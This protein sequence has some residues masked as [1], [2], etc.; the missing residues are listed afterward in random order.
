MNKLN[1]STRLFALIGL[2][3]LLLIGS[4]AV[5]IVGIAKTRD[6]L[7]QVYEQNTVPISRIA[8]IQERLLA[9]RLAITVALLT[10]DAATISQKTAEVDAN[11]QAITKVWDAHM[12][13]PMDE[14]EAALSK[15]FQA[16]RVR[17][18]QEGLKPAAAALR[19]ND[20]PEANRI[21]V[22]AIRPLYAAVDGGIKALMKDRLEGAQHEYDAAVARYEA[23]RNLSIGAIAAGV[24]F[25]VVFG[26]Y[27]VRSIKRPLDHAVQASNAV[28]KGDL[29]FPVDA[30]G[31]DEIASLLRSLSTMKDSLAGVVGGVR[32]NAEGVA[33]ASAQIAQ[34][35]GELSSRTEE[36]ASALEETAASMEE[37]S[38]TVKQNADNAKQAD[39]LAKGAC[40]VAVKGGEVVGQ[41]VETMKGI[42]ESS[43]RIADIIS[44]IDG[45]AFQTNILALNAA[46][47]AARAGEQGRG[48]AVVAGEVRTLAQRSA[49]AAKEIKSLISTSVE[50]VDQGSALVD[51]AGATMREVVD[52]IQRVTDI[53]SEISAA[54]HEQSAGV[55]QVGEAVSQMDQTTQQ[56]AAL[57][58]ESAA[59]AESLRV[60][61]QQ[62]LESVAVFHLSDVAPSAAGA[63]GGTVHAPAHAG[64]AASAVVAKLPARAGLAKR[65]APAAPPPSPPAHA[66]A[67]TGTD[68]WSSF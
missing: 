1:I 5:G 46:V 10:P 44:V 15:T 20:I 30:S 19:A 13:Q 57:V 18:V 14:S 8:E 45:I 24:L 50:R 62:L 61:A 59:A 4:G 56:N 26:F 53:M 34:G 35:N 49:E 31:R 29:T 6:A 68:D 66:A 11:I 48:F 60:Q 42:N 3:C 7:H 52:A 51:E 21:V 25:A 40:Q 12:A 2:L 9:N 23:T 16:D 43:R 67:A 65:A 22:H 41:V 47:E 54:S 32:R 27:L 63:G 39:Q 58:E 37:L 55:A 64:P 38:S 36:Q 28:A 17:F 33:T